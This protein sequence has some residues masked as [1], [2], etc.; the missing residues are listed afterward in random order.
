MGNSVGKSGAGDL[1]SCSLPRACFTIV[2]PS[3][4]EFEI[5]LTAIELDAGFGVP[6]GQ[7]RNCAA[8]AGTARVSNKRTLRRQAE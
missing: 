3:G 7:E 5:G 4:L 2:Q 8:E 6:E 1:T